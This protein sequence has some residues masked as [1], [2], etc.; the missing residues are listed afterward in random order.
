MTENRNTEDINEVRD[1]VNEAENIST[2][3]S[4]DLDS[5]NGQ[6]LPA[7]PLVESQSETTFTPEIEE[8]Q[9]PYEN[10]VAWWD[11]AVMVLM[12]ILSQFMGGMI[13]L[14]LGITPP[15]S[16][17]FESSDMEISELA[18]QAQA[19]FI[20]ISFFIAMLLCFGAL[21]IY[22]KLRK[23]PQRAEHRTP[24]WAASFR[25]LCGY[26]LLW[27]IS[28]A[29]EP[30]ISLLPESQTHMGS[31][32]WLLISA[33]ILAPIFEEIVFRGYIASLLRIA[34]GSI[35]A[36][37][38]S[39]LLF[40]IAHGE[41]ATIISATL[42]G[43]V[44]GFYFLRYRSLVMVILLHAMNNVTVCFLNM[45]GLN[46]IT[47]REIITDQNTYWIIQG[48]C[49]AISI[50]AFARMFYLIRGRKIN[51]YPSEK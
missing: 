44:L 24:G 40:G 6:D 36:W 45:F 25:L 1:M 27:C 28:I 51:K 46:D 17:L 31:G 9:K 14:K 13:A 15:D 49:S 21:H 8:P 11:I 33:V 35:T 7:D 43:L 26:I 48:A 18:Q 29:I 12:F 16:S 10:R 32:G 38:I 50:L 4:E 34:Y 5:L 37:I 19:R 47:L 39:S 42:S 41:S 30:I 20:A 22:H 2:S 23:L 3:K